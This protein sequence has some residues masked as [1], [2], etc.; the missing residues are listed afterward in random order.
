MCDADGI[1]IHCILSASCIRCRSSLDNICRW[2]CEVKDDVLN[3]VRCLHF[4]FL[5]PARC[6]CPILMFF[7]ASAGFMTCTV[8]VCKRKS[9]CCRSGQ[10]GRNHIS[11][12]TFVCRGCRRMVV[13]I[14]GGHHTRAAGWC[15]QTCPK[16]VA[17]CACTPLAANVLFL[18]EQR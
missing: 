7:G 10:P 12:C 6:A 14:S 2:Y 8:F 13:R 18:A 1:L 4:F 16:F 5:F 15:F 9:S 11:V 3:S 17:G